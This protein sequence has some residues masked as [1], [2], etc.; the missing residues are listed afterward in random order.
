MNNYEFDMEFN[1]YKNILYKY[2]GNNEKTEYIKVT[3]S[4]EEYFNSLREHY[5]ISNA[6]P[7]DERSE[8]DNYAD[9]FMFFISAGLIA[10][11][12]GNYYINKKVL[13]KYNDM[14]KETISKKGEA[15]K[16]N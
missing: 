15:K 16:F 9:S 11:V 13:Q 5:S 3:L 4:D 7:F 2:F 6:V 1:F 14:Y 10:V 8:E 12:E